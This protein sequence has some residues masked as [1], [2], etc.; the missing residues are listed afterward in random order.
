M[1]QLHFAQKPTPL[2][3]L[4]RISEKIGI[5]LWIK[6]DDL[7]GDMV[8]GGNKIRKLEYLLADAK[9]KGADTIVTTGGLQSNHTKI[10]AGLAVKLGMIPVLLLNGAEPAVK[11]AN[12]FI[13][14]LLVAELQYITAENQGEMNRQVVEAAKKLKEAGKNPYIVPV[15]GSTGL[16]AL[17]YVDAYSEVRQQQEREFD[18]EFVSAGSGGTL[19]GIFLGHQ[20]YNSDTKLIGVSPW[21]STEE[22]SAQTITCIDEGNQLLGN[23]SSDV[24]KL[25]IDDSYIGEG[26]GVPT[27]DGIKAI[28]M[29]MAHEGILLDHVYTGKAM[30]CLLDYVQ[31]GKIST[32]D[33]VLFW[34]TGGASGIFAV[35]D[36]WTE[37]EI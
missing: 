37:L 31:T 23:Q 6:R 17:G 12:T 35:A 24:S 8:T 3:Y 21:L 10:T 13:D 26:Y 30:A 9:A 4:P 7:T 2:E 1:N 32:G 11:K 5:E 22:I 14:S 36:R 20:Q 19:A 34:H 18:W 15:G 25:K 16:G 27:G 28:E 29:M 33:K